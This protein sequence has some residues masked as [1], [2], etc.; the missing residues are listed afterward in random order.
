MVSM[1]DPRP[2]TVSARPEPVTI[3]LAAT[4]VILVTTRLLDVVLT[5][6]GSHRAYLESNER[7]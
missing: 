7:H 6:L 2:V 1:P 4:A 5:L 3:D